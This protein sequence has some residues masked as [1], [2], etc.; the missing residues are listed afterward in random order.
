LYA[1]QLHRLHR[2]KRDAIIDE[3][4]PMLPKR[5]AK[6]EAGYRGLGY[7]VVDCA[8][9]NRVPPSREPTLSHRAS[10]RYRN[11]TPQTY[12]PRE[13]RSALWGLGRSAPQLSTAAL[14]K[15]FLGWP[16][17]DASTWRRTAHTI[18]FYVRITI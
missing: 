5:T 4:E 2:S 3:N 12:A 18:L 13:P 8:E 17:A 9:F 16:P 7:R 11:V 14:A 1:S 10:G 15:R 6:R